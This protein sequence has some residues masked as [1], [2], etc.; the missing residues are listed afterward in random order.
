[1]NATRMERNRDARKI[2]FVVAALTECG[3]EVGL[4]NARNEKIAKQGR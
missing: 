2:N 4:Q 3:D 1:M